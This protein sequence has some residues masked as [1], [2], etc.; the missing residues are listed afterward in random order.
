M[1][2]SAWHNGSGTYGISV[3]KPNRQAYFEESWD[4]VWVMI[5]GKDHRF[6]L[7]SGFWRKC[8]EF[9]DK[10][11][12]VI[13]DWLRKYKVLTWLKWKN[14]K[15]TLTKLEGNKFQLEP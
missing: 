4:H 15:A 10:G 9:R 1:I 8:P 11:G 12:T 6:E 14:P 7:T 5:E 3:G 2:V 13:Q